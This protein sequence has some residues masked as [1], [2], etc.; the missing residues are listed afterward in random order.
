MA[1]RKLTYTSL[2]DNKDIHS[3]YEQALN[4][5]RRVLGS[6]TDVYRGGASQLSRI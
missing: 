6:I 3:G 5:A 2:R 1:K 4:G